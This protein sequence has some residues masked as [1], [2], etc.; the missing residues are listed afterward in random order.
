MGVPARKNITGPKIHHAERD[1]YGYLVKIPRNVRP[2]LMEYPMKRLAVCLGVFAMM[3]CFFVGGVSAQPDPKLDP[4][5]GSTKL[6]A[7]FLPDPHS[8]ELIAGGPIKTNLG[9]VTAYVA[10]APDYRL[11]YKAGDFP[12]TFY[13]KS[14]GD[15]TLLINLPDGTWIA[16]DD[17]GG[18]PNPKI[19]LAKPKSGIY[20]FYVG[21]IKK[22][23]ADAK[24]TLYITELEVKEVK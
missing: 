15:T 19:T 11:E 21:T 24:A 8:K 20:D 10:K 5:F 12:L 4:T 17:G 9:G 1:D 2:F 23:E 14:K 6:T 22:D 13:V 18:F 7:G 16:D 3:A